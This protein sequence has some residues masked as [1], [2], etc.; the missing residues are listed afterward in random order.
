M[1][2]IGNDFFAF[3]SLHCLQLCGC[4]PLLYRCSGVPGCSTDLEIKRNCSKRKFFCVRPK[5]L[6]RV[7]DLDQLGLVFELNAVILA[8]IFSYVFNPRFLYKR[9]V[10]KF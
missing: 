1:N 6:G 10:L 7:P 9:Y 4:P 5:E 8:D 3:M 2:I